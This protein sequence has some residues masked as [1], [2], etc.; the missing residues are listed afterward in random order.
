[1]PHRHALGQYFT[2]VWIAEAL[3]EQYFRHLTSDDVI[4]DPAAGNGSFLLAIPPHGPEAIGVE[5]DPVLADEART[6]TGR[7]VLTGDFR[8]VTL[9]KQ[10][11]ALI[12]NPPF[13]SRLIEQFLDR[14]RTLLPEGGQVGFILPAYFMQTSQRTVQ[15]MTQWSIETTLIPRDLFM[16]L[17][18]SLIFALF[19][20]DRKRTMIGLTLFHEAATIRQL[21]TRFRSI[22]QTASPGIWVRV[23]EQALYELGGTSTLQELYHT[24][25]SR[26]PTSNKFWEAKIRQT[27]QVHSDRFERIKPGHYRLR[28][29]HYTVQ[30][31]QPLFAYA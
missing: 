29:T 3:Y 27:L 25:K 2:N 4:V 16:R 28:T 24:L 10:P 17:K 19:R 23:V 14:A 11:T 6:R 15:Y 30:T 13:Q 8:T 20:K 9:P 1:M 7:M 5:L 12:G 18:Y 31:Q 26:R 21:P 22:A